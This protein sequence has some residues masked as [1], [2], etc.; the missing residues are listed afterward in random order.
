MKLPAVPQPR[1]PTGGYGRA[2]R[3]LRAYRNMGQ[4]DLA[5]RSGFSWG[6]ISK[7]EMGKSGITTPNRQILAEALNVPYDVFD[8]LV[9]GVDPLVKAMTGYGPMT[10]A[11]RLYTYGQAAVKLKVCINTVRKAVNSG[12]VTP[13]R[14]FRACWFTDDDLERI[15]AWQRES[16]VSSRTRL[17]RFQR[18]K[19]AGLEAAA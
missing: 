4:K 12:I 2:L 9:Y 6:A 5:A 15:A 1:K 19:R 7:W 17:R 18:N 11:R 16:A 3:T 8:A 13:K 10:E 14:E